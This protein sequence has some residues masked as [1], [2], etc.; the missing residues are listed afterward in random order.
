MESASDLE[1]EN[2]PRFNIIYLGPFEEIKYISTST[3]K[4][5]YQ[6]VYQKQH[7]LVA[8]TWIFNFFET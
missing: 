3:C 8:K 5:L 6:E 1:T 2:S 4:I 7:I